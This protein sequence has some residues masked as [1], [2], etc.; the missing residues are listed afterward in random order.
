MSAY[1]FAF[2]GIIAYY[3]FDRYA[4]TVIYLPEN[5]ERKLPFDSHPRLRIAGEVADFPVEGAWQPAGD[6]RRY[7]ILSKRFLRAAGVAVGDVVE[8]RFGIADQN[9]VMVPDALVAALTRNRPLDRKWRSLT[10]G[11]QR[12][13]AHRVA[14]AKT[15]ATQA[16]RIAEVFEMIE[17]GERPGAS[18]KKK[19]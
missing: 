7:F 18:T 8:M 9:A 17:R 11:A 6:G 5:L 19:R 15:E 3:T 4:Y 2:E 1:P 14:T 10:P 16:R 12:A 13:F